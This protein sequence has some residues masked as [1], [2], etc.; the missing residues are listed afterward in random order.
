MLCK[1]SMI[2]RVSPKM[3]QAQGEYSFAQSQRQQGAQ[4]AL[5]GRS[6]RLHSFCLPSFCHVSTRLSPCFHYVPRPFF[7]TGQLGLACPS[8]FSKAS[9]RRCFRRLPGG[10]VADL[11]PGP[12]LS[13]PRPPHGRGCWTPSG[14]VQG[15]RAG[16]K[17]MEG[18]REGLL[19][20]IGGTEGRA[21]L[22]LCGSLGAQ[23]NQAPSP[24]RRSPP[25][26]RARAQGA[27][28]PLPSACR[29]FTLATAAR[30]RR[31]PGW[32]RMGRGRAAPVRA[33]AEARAAAAAQQSHG[34]G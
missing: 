11:S 24:P 19:Q 12:Q 7:L 32:A 9:V 5:W 2:S 1:V 23:D 18:K 14:P 25:G 31:A 4:G 15:L 16:G 29:P 34:R 27:P 20:T 17:R 22:S 33:E 30:L 6:P 21:P 10:E 26:S 13:F 28:R 8:C 3:K